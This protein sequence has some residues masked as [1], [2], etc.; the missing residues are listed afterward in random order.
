MFNHHEIIRIA[1]SA[2]SMESTIERNNTFVEIEQFSSYSFASVGTAAN[3][4][5]LFIDRMT[6]LG[7]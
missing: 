4:G 2:V 1:L 7:V 3:W 6:I 5:L